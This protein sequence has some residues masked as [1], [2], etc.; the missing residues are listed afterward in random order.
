MKELTKVLL[1][2]VD[3]GEKD[4]ES[5]MEEL[6]S[7]SEACGKKPVGVMTQRL[8][9]VNKAFYMGA[10]KVA[11]AVQYAGECGA[12]EIIFDNTLSPSQMRNLAEQFERPIM[13]RTGLILDIFALRAR[14]AEARLQVEMAK[15]QYMLPRLV[16]MRTSLGRQGG[17]GGSMSN[18]GSGEKQLELDRRKIEHR[19]SEL[20]KEMENVSRTGETKRKKRTA[21]QIPQVALVG[22]T[23]AG[24][25]T[26]MNR[27]LTTY[28]K[29]PEKQVFEEDM[30]FATLETSV[31]L[32][33]PGDKRP[34]FL[35]DTVGFINKLPHGLVEA[36]RSTLDEVRYASLLVQVVDVSDSNYRSHMEV[37]AKTLEELKIGD[38][39]QLIVYNKADKCFLEDIPRVSGNCIH[40]A[41][42]SGCG[43][44]ELTNM[45]QD[46]LYTDLITCELLLPYEAGGIA[47]ELMERGIVLEQDYR[48]EGLFLRVKCHR[49]DADKYMCF[50]LDV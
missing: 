21:S 36:F 33:D 26:I 22:Y 46:T 37:T 4:F 9:S 15:L 30:L 40:M 18:K 8:E 16:G 24:K 17:T 42:G 47:S 41:A 14:T 45:I 5:S 20:K 50:R 23:N 11:E 13:D 38:I 29:V 43:I 25:S 10:G 44:Q 39:P 6:V 12:E 2:G 3:I 48:N 31:R 35:S 32:I 34:F 7:L 19:I 28:G 49:Q 1:V 27:M